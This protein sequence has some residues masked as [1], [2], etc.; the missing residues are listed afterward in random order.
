MS[1]SPANLFVE[2]FIEAGLWGADPILAAP[3]PSEHF[4]SAVEDC[5][6]LP[7][8][9]AAYKSLKECVE[10]WGGSLV[11]NKIAVMRAV[12]LFLQRIHPRSVKDFSDND[13]FE[14]NHWLYLL[15]GVRST[16][17]Y[18]LLVDSNFL[19]ARGPLARGS[20]DE[21][22]SSAFCLS[23][24]FSFLSVVDRVL[25][26]DKT[27]IVADFKRVSLSVASGVGPLSI[28]EESV[29]FIP[30][31]EAENAFIS[32]P[33]EEGGRYYVN[34][35]LQD[36]I[37]VPELIDSVLKR[38]VFSDV[39][40][41]PELVVSELDAKS[42]SINL[43]RDPGRV[44]ILLAGSGNT[45]ARS[46]NKPWNESNIL[47]GIGTPLIRQRKIWQAGLD[48]KRAVKLGLSVPERGL[49]MEDNCA[50][51][52]ISV[53]DV[54]GFGRC[55][56]LICQDFQMNPLTDDL[57]RQY[58]PDWVFVPILDTGVSAGRWVHQRAYQLSALSPA[59][60]LIGSS[61]SHAAQLRYTNYACGMAVGPKDQLG[62]DAGR[63]C[64]LA[65]SSGE[66]GVGTLKWRGRW[67]KT[68]IGLFTDD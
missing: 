59:R 10:S 41:I 9:K 50:G 33:R 66:P 5:L 39:V 6:K 24:M 19:I 23:D 36:E 48:K 11:T 61:T 20:R 62:P 34:F 54:D 60:F 46:F 2:Y 17:G 53:L 64:A 31:A 30:V 68:D 65:F 37:N 28:G 21:F 14:I 1:N 22:A 7:D 63:V 57:I 51:N 3:Q 32:V 49:V 27:P 56:I 8:G 13:E 45:T 35:K 12:D 25:Y 26:N 44:R 42:I 55:V 15:R 43:A 47:N 67:G 52:E 18:Y 29:S 4:I 16:K 38:I 58:Q 40:I